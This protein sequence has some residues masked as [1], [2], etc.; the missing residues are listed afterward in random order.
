MSHVMV[1]GKGWV[2]TAVAA[3]ASGGGPVTSIDP[4]FEPALADRDADATAALRALVDSTGTTQ[5]INACGRVAGTDDELADANVGF[6]DWL[7][8]ALTGTGV[9]LVHIGSASEYGDPGGPTSVGEDDPAHPAGPYAATKARGTEIVQD[10]RA[11]GLDAVVARVFNIVGSPVPAMSPLHQWREDLLALGPD[12]GE[13]EVWWPATTRDF[14]AIEDV[15]RALVEL[16][17]PGE[18]PGLVNVCSGVGLAFGE[19][20]EAMG[21]QL[22]IPVDVRSLER[23]GIAAVV[24]DPTRLRRVLGWSPEMTL[25]RLASIVA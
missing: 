6:V 15:A 24:G 20:V 9:R 11:H 25:D 19:I 2:G 5:V 21:R 23:P 7:C 18:R 8:E 1:L 3:V 10:A 14:V 16:A 4:P 13:V 12:G 22:G 17:A